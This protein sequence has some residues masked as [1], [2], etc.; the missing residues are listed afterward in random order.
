M[1]WRDYA[2]P[3]VFVVGLLVV[4]AGCSSSHGTAKASDT[5]VSTSTST[6]SAATSTTA[7]P[8]DIPNSIPYVVGE[9]IGLPNNWLVT[10]L[11]VHL[12]DAPAGL[13][14]AGSG[15]Q[16][17]AID[18]TMEYQGSSTYTVDAN[19]LFTLVDAAHQE[20][21]VIPEPGT[22]NGIDGRYATGTTRTGRLIFKAPIGQDLGLVL[23]GP[24][25]G[26]QVSDFTIV[27]P[28]VP[29]ANN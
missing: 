7:N 12:H 24:R 3:V 25:I 4:A 1:R 28:T 13:A 8:M 14:P 23:Y 2:G 16:Y 27:P 19:S 5:T 6:S 9:K 15:K 26:S 29:A 17:V 22:P 18:L 20:L 11:D 10:V 21:F